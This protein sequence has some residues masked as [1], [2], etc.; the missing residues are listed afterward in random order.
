[1]HHMLGSAT[2]QSF[3]EPQFFV[4]TPSETQNFTLIDENS[5]FT[6]EDAADELQRRLYSDLKEKVIQIQ[7]DTLSNKKYGIL[8]QE[9][10]LQ[11]E[12]IN[13][14]LKKNRFDLKVV[15]SYTGDIWLLS[16]GLLKQIK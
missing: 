4:F 10:K 6:P 11:K 3:N 9:Q 8:N 5:E 1:M 15:D 7:S 12:I 16:K 14:T 2:E 13:P